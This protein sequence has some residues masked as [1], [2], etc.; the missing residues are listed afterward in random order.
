MSNQIT[1]APQNLGC[2]EANIPDFDLIDAVEVT[3]ELILAVDAL[4]EQTEQRE[5][6]LCELIKRAHHYLDFHA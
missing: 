3:E 2:A 5:Q 4:A 1:T 6:Y